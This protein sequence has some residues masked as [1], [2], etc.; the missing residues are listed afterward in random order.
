MP[1]HAVALL[2][3]PLRSMTAERSAP[4]SHASGIPEGIDVRQE[5]AFRPLAEGVREAV[6]P[7]VPLAVVYGFSTR[8]GMEA[9]LASGLVQM[10]SLCR[11]LIAEPDL[12]EK[13]RTIEGYEAAC[14]RCGK[15]WPEAI[16]E[17]TAC[18]NA[19]VQ[20]KLR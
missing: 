17:G 12:P 6:G 20:R 5:A 9:V 13:L 10:V 8:A 16:G 15:C 19:A 4:A 14:V 2:N 3:T 7:E 11:P 18:R 1:T